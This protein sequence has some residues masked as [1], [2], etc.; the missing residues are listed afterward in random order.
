VIIPVVVVL[1]GS[2]WAVF[3]LAVLLWM[4]AGISLEHDPTIWAPLSIAF[5]VIGLACFGLW[6]A[7]RRAR[8]KLTLA[9]HRDG[10]RYKRRAF[11]FD[12]IGAIRF[13]RK[14]PW[15]EAALADIC[16][17][18]G[19]LNRGYGDVAEL[20][21]MVNANSLSLLLKDGRTYSLRGVAIRCEP[22]EFE[23]FLAHLHAQHPDL[24]DGGC[25]KPL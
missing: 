5:F 13:G 6:I 17:L 9:L 12:Q 8:P 21:D 18:I 22:R 4:I 15:V 14:S 25:P 11:R 1:L 23:Q 3:G 24:F 2:A 20:I 16:R 19:R 7:W 10:I